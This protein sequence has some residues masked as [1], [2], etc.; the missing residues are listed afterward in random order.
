ME[1]DDGGLVALDDDEVHAVI[2]GELG[3]VFFELT[4]ILSKRGGREQGAY[5]GAPAD[6]H[7]MTPS[8]LSLFEF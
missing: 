1:R 2:E 8:W 7:R 4:Q 3:N 6:D 5:G